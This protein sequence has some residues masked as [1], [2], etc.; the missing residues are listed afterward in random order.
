MHGE[1][2]SISELYIF[3]NETN[4]PPEVPVNIPSAVLWKTSLEVYSE[5]ARGAPSNIS[6]EVFVIIFL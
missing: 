5:M 1:L 6:G 4:M 2:W 3:V